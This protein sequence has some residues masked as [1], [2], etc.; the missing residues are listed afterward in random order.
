MTIKAV[1]FDMGNTLVKYDVDIFEEVYDRILTS[2]GISRSIDEI[3]RAFEK[4]EEEAKKNGLLSSFG[5]IACEEFWHCWDSLILKHLNI[6]EKEELA[7]TIQSKWFDFLESTLYPE[8]REVLS[9]LRNRQ[10]KVGL[11][12]TAYEEEIHLLMKKIGLEKTTFDVIVGVDTIK[13]AKPD[14]AVFKYAI[15][16]LN[17]APEE[18]MFVG[19]KIEADYKGAKNAGLHALLINRS[20]NPPKELTIIGNLTEILTRIG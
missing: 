10:V 2:L 11:I 3:K 6:T 8:V 15:N 17:V 13:K 5:K 12:S 7:G 1:L 20:E 4:T 16:Q 14:P 19:D 9:E 18:T